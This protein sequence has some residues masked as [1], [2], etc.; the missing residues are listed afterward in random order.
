MFNLLVTRRFFSHHFVAV[1]SALAVM[2]SG[3]VIG[4]P[5]VKADSYCFEE[6]YYCAE[7]AGNTS[8][9]YPETIFKSLD[10]SV[11]AMMCLWEEWERGSDNSTSD[12]YNPDE[13]KTDQDDLDS[14]GYNGYDSE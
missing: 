4:V 10:C 9:S 13:Y 6:M 7:D 3:L 2:F 11:D 5:E 8:D 1:P 14:N 12:E